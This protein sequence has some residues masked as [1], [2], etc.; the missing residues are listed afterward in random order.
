MENSL[1]VS[2]AIGII[3][4]FWPRASSSEPDPT[5]QK[6][7][8]FESLPKG[9]DY[10]QGVPSNKSVSRRAL[11]IL[12]LAKLQGFQSEALPATDGGVIMVLSKGDYFL[13]VSIDPDLTLNARIEK[14]IGSEYEVL[15]ESE[16]VSKADVYNL[17]IQTKELYLEC[18]SSV[19][20][21]KTSIAL[22]SADSQQSVSDHTE[23]EFQ[24]S[25]EFVLC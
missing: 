18:P 20:Y 1:L 7:L 6:I 10:G 8:S 11:E 24:Y 19:P 14:G 12:S 22:P 4:N 13:D 3:Q 2:T 21:T 25:M 16:D 9:W 5:V 17:L 15:W 23:E